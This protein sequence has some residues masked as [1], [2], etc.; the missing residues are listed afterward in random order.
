MTACITECHNGGPTT[1]KK[2][3]R[4][5]GC[6]LDEQKKELAVGADVVEARH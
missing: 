6:V 4:H 3:A 2:M 1:Q 5:H